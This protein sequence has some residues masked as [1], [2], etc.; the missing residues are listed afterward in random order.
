MNKGIEIHI[1]DPWY[2]HIKSGTKDVEGKVA[3]GKALLMQKGHNIR[4][5]GNSG[6]TLDCQIVDI[7]KYDSFVDYLTTEGLARTLPGVSSLEEGLAVYA[8]YYEPGLDR[9]L[10]VLAVE[11][12]RVNAS[13]TI[14]SK[15]AHCPL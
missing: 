12:N 5:S 10:G 13:G 3:K 6:E 4:I 14:V 7:R 15:D 9:K 11:L 2:G 8:Q 1:A